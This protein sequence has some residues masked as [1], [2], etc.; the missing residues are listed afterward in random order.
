MILCNFGTYSSITGLL[1]AVK[2]HSP[3][4][5]VVFQLVQYM[6]GGVLPYCMQHVSENTA[7]ITN[8]LRKTTITHLMLLYM[9]IFN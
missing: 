6:F 5:F 4:L 2:L 7:S 1:A 9:G 8:L 3:L